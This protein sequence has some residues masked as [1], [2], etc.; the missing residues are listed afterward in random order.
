MNIK[1]GQSE[2][3]LIVP[4]DI[5]ALIPPILAEKQ[6]EL[7]SALKTA[8]VEADLPLY[9]FLSGADNLLIVVPDH[10][11]RCGL[12]KV[13]PAVLE[14]IHKAGLDS[15]NIKILAAS[16]T[17]KHIGREAYSEILGEKIIQRFEIYE[18]DHLKDTVR[19]GHT[20]R[21]SPVDINR[22]CLE[23][24]R[25]LAV[26]GMLPHYF[27]GFGGGP[28]LLIPGCSSLETILANHA[29]RLKLQ[30]DWYPGQAPDK[31]EDNELIQ[32][33]IEGVSL[34]PPVYHIGIILG[35]NEQPYRIFAGE[36]ISTYENM[37]S[38]AEKLFNVSIPEK[39]D[40]VIV[41][42]GGYPKD[43]DLLQSHKSLYH[44]SAALKP[45]G[46]ML[47]FADCPSGIG[48]SSLE[49]L[50]KIGEYD[51]IVRSLRESYKMNGQAAVSLMKM[52]MIFD[53]RIKTSLPDEILKL[54]NFSR[55]NSIEE[56]QDIINYSINK[57]DTIFFFPNASITRCSL[58]LDS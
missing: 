52:G 34:L 35:D 10:T 47:V 9:D 42:A 29:L 16:G 50:L 24:D 32:D 12:K 31:F 7:K 18:N 43:I 30:P 26:G 45:G 3:R 40:T 58:I 14:E 23:A 21:G 17:H 51:E 33:I 41:S 37:V 49:S 11:R 56:A 19:I 54:M 6:P 22:L 1:Y 53:M 46:K 27:A 8:F 4:G 20:R 44:A 15:D 25:I 2:I 48:S 38:E 13:L 36:L 39:A 55:L 28:K 57:G 5:P